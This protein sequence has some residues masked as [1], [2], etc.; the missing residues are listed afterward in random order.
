MI[1][2]TAELAMVPYGR[3]YFPSIRRNALAYV[4]KTRYIEV[5]EKKIGSYPFI[6]RPRRFGKTLFTSMLRSYYDRSEAKDFESHFKGTYIYEH[7]TPLQGQYYVLSLD[8]SGLQG[9]KNVEEVQAAFQSAV[10]NRLRDFFNRYPMAGSDDV[11][12]ARHATPAE[13]IDAFFAFVKPQVQASLFVII[14]EYDQ[15]ANEIL[16]TDVALFKQITSKEGFLKSFYARLKAATSDGVVDRTFIT[17]VTT[18]SLDSMTSGF[19][20]ADLVTADRQ[21][22][23]AFGFTEPELRDLIVRTVDLK[24]AGKPIEAILQ[25]MKDC[26]NG[27]RFSPDSDVTVFNAS[28]CLYYLRRLA[29]DGEEPSNLMDPAFSQDLMKIEKILSLS[30]NAGLLQQVVE[31]ALLGR[32][33]EFSGVLRELNL[34]QS[35]GFN[36]EEVLSLLCYLGY[37]TFSRDSATALVCPNQV[38]REK[39]FG[40]YFERI[41]KVGALAYQEAELTQV[42]REVAKTEDLKPFLDYIARRIDDLLGL[43]GKKSLKEGVIEMACLMGADK[44]PLY[45]VR[46]EVEAHGRGVAD[47]LVT[48]KASHPSLPAFVLELK[49]VPKSRATRAVLDAR[50]E[51][52]R[53]Q[54]ARYAQAENL[55]AGGRP[56]H[57]VAAV[58]SGTAIV[59]YGLDRA[60]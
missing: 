47:L 7:K 28:M 4:D 53:G 19:N 58:F 21:L 60:A 54:L 9:G 34:N 45:D 11:L 36:R 14:D 35:D 38:V 16:A 18:V 50:L 23:G 12:A 26:Y 43:Q 30:E 48:P 29:A 52:A 10:R 57:R 41:A 33:L 1:E 5:L 55:T 32:P 37:L 20:I 59:R 51:E 40:V 46:A 8:F 49:Y 15:F 13:Q 42:F 22:A 56:R 31:S 25:R 39:F 27:Y 44:N 2:S 24:A 6:V 3:A 17:G